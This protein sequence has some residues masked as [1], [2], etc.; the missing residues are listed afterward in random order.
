MKLKIT[1]RLPLW[2]DI[3]K[4][5]KVVIVE[6]PNCDFKW[7]PTYEQL[8]EIKLNLDEIEKKSWKSQKK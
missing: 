4:D 3:N 7:I 1:K 6:F 2:S 8:K 5:R